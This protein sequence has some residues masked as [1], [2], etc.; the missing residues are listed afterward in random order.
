LTIQ[1]TYRLGAVDRRELLFKALAGLIGGA[2]GWIPVE[3]A[4]NGHSLTEVQTTWTIVASFVSMALMAGAIGG[5]IMAA[6]EQRLEISPAARRR[7]LRGFLICAA[8]SI[9]ATY[10]SD[11][12]FSA[13]LAA[14]GWGV[15]H[16]GSAAYMVLARVTGWALMGLSLG[17]GVGLASLS[18][19][20]ILK[21]GLGGVIGG[22]LGGLGFDLIG[23]LSQS[24]LMPRLVGFSVI[25]LAIGLFIGLVQELTKA[26]WL[27]VEAGRLRGRQFRLD[28]AT[29]SIGRA[30]ENPVGLFGDAAVQPRHAVIERHGESY[31]LR[32]LAV[33]AGTFVNGNR[34]ENTELREGDR[35]RIGAYE[36]NFHTRAE[37]RA[38]A[39]V[40]ASA[41]TDAKMTPVAA[42]LEPAD[43]APLLLKAGAP[44][45]LGRALDNDIILNDASISRYHAVIEA[46]NGSFLVRDLGS[47]NGTWLAGQRVTEAN[48]T[49]GAELRLGD[50]SF[51]FYG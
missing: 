9:P 7:F 42:R 6:Q 3:I 39:P 34:V 4:S 23:S 50:A 48:L 13:I 30:E 47:H 22:F 17:V 29:L 11:A 16:A 10:Y 35:I 21:G 41:R 27:V 36:L 25:G 5:M 38:G 45:R 44:T 15:D 12:L 31:T 26:A 43:G 8:V 1:E 40:V 33:A 51:T 20:N 19:Q 14:G 46:R 24:G 18:L 37:A 32:N 28:G 2:I 49:R